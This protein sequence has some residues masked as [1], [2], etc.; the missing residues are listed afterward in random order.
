V[1]ISMFSMT[2]GLIEIFIEMVLEMFPNFPSE[3]IGYDVEGK[4][5]GSRISVKMRVCI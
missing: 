2:P 4:R 3:R 5:D 1:P